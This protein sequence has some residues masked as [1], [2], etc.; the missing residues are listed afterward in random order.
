MKKRPALIIDHEK[1]RD[2]MKAVTGWCS[3]AGIDVAGVFKVTNGLASTALD[4]EARKSQSRRSKD[5][6]ADDP[7]TYA[8]GTR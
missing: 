4:Y 2:N 1:L 6:D 3:E 5:P 7:R 8:L